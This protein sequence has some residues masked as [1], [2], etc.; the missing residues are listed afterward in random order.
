MI[1]PTAAP[2]PQY[3]HYQKSNL[4]MEFGEKCFMYKEDETEN[5]KKKTSRRNFSR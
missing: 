5:D 4:P 1:P 2:T 3:Y